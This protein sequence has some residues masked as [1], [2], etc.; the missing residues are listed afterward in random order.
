M[1]KLLEHPLEANENEIVKFNQKE[2]E[3]ETNLF[4]NSSLKTN[5]I[6]SYYFSS[7][8]NLLG[9]IPGTSTIISVEGPFKSYNKQ[10]NILYTICGDVYY[11]DP[12]KAE[13][14]KQPP[15]YDRTVKML[16]NLQK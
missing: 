11:L 4:N 8:G 13:T 2:H 14:T 15:I 1:E 9:L 7:K 6:D 12:K 16:K 5:K 3:Y 10:T